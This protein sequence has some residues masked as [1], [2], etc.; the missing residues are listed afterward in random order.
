MALSEY[1]A[2]ISAVHIMAEMAVANNVTQMGV[3][4]LPR[5][6]VLPAVVCCVLQPVLHRVPCQVLRY[7]LSQARCATHAACLFRNSYGQSYAD[8]DCRKEPKN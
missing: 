5:V 1:P 2:H 3:A 6:H 8:R 7:V 4:R